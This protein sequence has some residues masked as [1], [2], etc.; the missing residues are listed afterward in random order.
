MDKDTEN[1]TIQEMGGKVAL[2]GVVWGKIGV[3]LLV[4]SFFIAILLTGYPALNDPEVSQ[5]Y[6]GD[7]MGVVSPGNPVGQTLV[8]RRPKMNG[9]TFWLYPVNDQTYIT[10]DVFPSSQDQEMIFS[11]TFQVI[12]GANHVT[13]HPALPSH[14]TSYYFRL[15]TT[16]GQIAVSGRREDAFSK[17]T[18]YEND[19]P[20]EGD[21]A[22]QITYAYDGQAIVFD[23]G[24]LATQWLPLL[25]MIPLLIFPG[26]LVLDTFGLRK[27]FDPGET[28]ALSVGLSL[29]AIPLLML[30]TT[31]LRLPWTQPALLLSTGALTAIWLC[32][33][34]SRF[35][36]P[37]LTLKEHLET[38]KP[39]LHTCLLVG[40]FLFSFFLRMAMV[41]DLTVPPW[42]DSVHHGLITRRIVQT[43]G[44]PDHYLPHI[45]LDVRY[46]HPGYHIILA[47]Y[48]WLSGLSIPQAML[49]LGQAL[50]ALSVFAVYALTTALVKD[51]TTAIFASLITGIF[52]VMPA[53]YTTWGRY[54]QLTGLLI[55]PTT[56][57][58]FQ[59]ISTE[60]KRIPWLLTAAFSLGGL[61]LVHYRAAFFTG[62]LLL[63]IWI[64]DLYIHKHYSWKRLRPSI[65][66]YALTGLFGF[67]LVAPWLLPTLSHF[68]LPIAQRWGTNNQGIQPIHWRYFTEACGIPVLILAGFGLIAGILQRRRF[69]IILLL[70]CCSLFLAANPSYFHLPFP[71]SFINQTS[72]EIILFI[73]ISI[74]AGFWLSESF[75]WINSQYQPKSHLFW[76]V[77]L[78]IIGVE[79]TVLGAQNLLPILNPVTVLFR[80]GDQAAIDWIQENIDENETV[81]INPTG[82]GYGLYRGQDG[83]YWIS[84]ITD[85]QTMPPNVLY[86]FSKDKTLMVNHFVER[87]LL[88]GDKPEEIWML[89]D[90]YGYQTIFIGT[91]GGVLS[92]QAL[93][94]SS[95]FKVLYQK[96]ITWVFE[97]VGINQGKE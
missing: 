47:A 18:A 55:L 3:V 79:I 35:I 63:A 89:L 26:W 64:S 69:S 6:H 90:E 46:Y 74:C 50:N 12:R 62:C 78:L 94:E 23:L 22:F 34:I 51:K 80:D 14:S 2:S 8:V 44:L 68:F 83:G 86:G 75:S 36:K 43:G 19:L 31:Y 39:S 48:H 45:P 27:H 41:R 84:P 4:V 10:L 1:L 40:I 24:Y 16:Q 70:W 71:T 96:G 97:A 88:I 54:T 13:I 77:I 49:W 5:T 59:K 37:T 72:V 73:P 57:I 65:L 42:V 87:I 58:L 61:I 60:K 17:G 11:S 32:R 7:V 92:P 66:S 29:A 38:V 28:V 25:G 93:V 21:L 81:V 95:L 15:R 67:L 9:I 76:K 85:R 56:L 53:Y 20:M 82:W 30:W 52:S 91:Q 33:T